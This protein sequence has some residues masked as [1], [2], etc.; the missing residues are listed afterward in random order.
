MKFAPPPSHRRAL[1]F[2]AP[3]SWLGIPIALQAL[4]V[5]LTCGR[6][7]RAAD[8]PARKPIPIVRPV[9]THVLEF[10]RDILPLFR[11]N[12][13]PC[14]NRT[15]SKAD[16][17]LESPAD[18]L[19]GGESGPALI[20]GQSKNSL[21]VKVSAHIEKPR[22][23]PKEN[24]VNAVNFTPEQLGIL[25]LWIDQGARAGERVAEVIAWQALPERVNPVLAVAVP[26]N[27][28]Y[29]A[30]GRGNQV[31]VYRMTDGT[32]L[33]HLSDPALSSS[34]SARAIAHRD[35]VNALAFSPD[36]EWLASGGFREVK[37]WRRK[38]R[39]QPV[40]GAAAASGTNGAIL[41]G[42]RGVSPDGRIALTLTD[43]R[44]LLSDA[45]ARHWVMVLTTDVPDGDARE[46]ARR[47]LARLKT[48]K[49]A[50]QATVEA[51]KKEL[52]GQR[53]RLR[54]ADAA[55]A[56]AQSAVSAKEPGI[57][58]AQKA[59]YDAET[60]V[61]RLQR[62]SGLPPVTE[63]DRTVVA[64]K[65][66]AAGKEVEKVEAEIK[67]LIQKLESARNE[68]ELTL[69][70]LGRA[71]GALMA[72]ES[73]SRR[74]AAVL[75]QISGRVFEAEAACNRGLSRVVA[76]ALSP[77][78]RRV[79]TAHEDGF[80]RFWNAADGTALDRWRIPS[81]VRNL[82]FMPSGGL[83]VR[84]SESEAI[85]LNAEPEWVLTRSLG[86]ATNEPAF[87]DRV[88]ALAFRPDGQRL[89]VGGGEPTRSGD[90][91]V[92]DPATGQRI[93]SIPS[94][95][96]D[97]ILSL[98]YS[99]DGNG[100]V[101]GGADR[102]ARIVDSAAGRQVR[103]LEGHSGHVLGVAWSPEGSAIATAGADLV[104]KFW[105][106]VTG[107]KRKQATGFTHEATSVAF[108]GAAGRLVVAS[109][110]GELRLIDDAGAKVSGFEGPTDFVYG[111]GISSDAQWIVAGGQD[112]LLRFWRNGGKEAVRQLEDRRPAT[113][114]H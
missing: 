108:L 19:K 13:L 53:D 3:S 66:T 39:E 5:V 99:P 28:R 93:F 90:L 103:V 41:P 17:L 42:G 35:T 7:V 100:L 20:P 55:L 86:S 109:G 1:R 57:V 63:K 106:A 43:G 37:L 21:V 102:F 95:H 31:D 98:A 82:G 40:H 89:A 72:A 84:T 75:E 15:T 44:A 71:E 25:A 14:H 111:L 73:A 10:Y 77:D 114:A 80:L 34:N 94:L 29:A 74:T 101:T 50:R 26:A 68:R 76:A 46:E 32:E 91:S 27:G 49:A 65:V 69:G 56:G 54:R 45:E 33:G 92:W 113:G 110:D 36:G 23:P 105:D 85:R 83:L 96:S 81:A 48:E 4:A 16:L 58:A 51:V 64:E 104:V 88:N 47:S 112:R 38:F 97:S 22:M 67:P 2:P 52:D 18:L 6:T 70:A 11:E 87:S 78:S 59:R 12:C 8:E 9:A 79:V 24:K 61:V 30:C 62:R 60:G 107:E